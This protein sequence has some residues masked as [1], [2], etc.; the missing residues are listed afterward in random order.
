MMVNYLFYVNRHYVEGQDEN[1]IKSSVG[2]D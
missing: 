2:E 1:Y